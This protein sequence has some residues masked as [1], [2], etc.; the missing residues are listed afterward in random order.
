MH[1]VPAYERRVLNTATSSQRLDHTR[2]MWSDPTSRLIRRPTHPTPPASAAAQCLNEHARNSF[3]NLPREIRDRVYHFLLRDAIDVRSSVWTANP[4]S[5]HDGLL[6]VC[7]QLHDET[8]TTIFA[9]R[10]TQHRT[11]RLTTLPATSSTFRNIRS[12][13][14]EVAPGLDMTILEGI[15]QS[16]QE[17]QLSLQELRL[18]FLT[19]NFSLEP[20][21]YITCGKATDDELIAPS[22]RLTLDPAFVLRQLVVLRKLIVLRQ[23]R[24]LIVENADT[25]LVPAMMCKDKPHLTGLAVV[26]SPQALLH[27][28]GAL[29]LSP[30]QLRGLMV[31]PAPFSDLKVLELSA[32]AVIPAM[33]LLGGAIR[34]L[35]H[36]SWRVPNSDFQDRKSTKFQP[37]VTFYKQTGHM[38]RSLA[39]WNQRLKVLRLCIDLPSGSDYSL[40]RGIAVGDVEGDFRAYLCQLTGLKH[41]E[42]HHSCGRGFFRDELISRLPNGLARLYISESMISIDELITQVQHRFFSYA[43]HYRPQF[44]VGLTAASSRRARSGN[45]AKVPACEYPQDDDRIDTIYI[46]LDESHGMYDQN[47][48]TTTTT[49]VC[50]R[51][52]SRKEDFLESTLVDLYRGENLIGESKTQHFRDN[53]PL[54]TGHLGFITYEY[55]CSEYESEEERFQDPCYE[56]RR[57]SLLK[58]NGRLLDREHNM[59]LVHAQERETFGIEP[60]WLKPAIGDPSESDTY[61]A[62]YSIHVGIY[63]SHLRSDKEERKA[64]E[65]MSELAA[66]FQNNTA[67]KEQHWYFG[68]ESAAQ[69]VFRGEP[70][71]HIANIKHKST[72]ADVEAPLTGRC[73]WAAPEYDVPAIGTWAEPVMPHGWR[74][75]LQTAN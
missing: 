50:P 35:E 38:I 13:S 26:S 34:S 52:L 49:C 51:L 45:V 20:T 42:I 4:T 65:A 19:D 75:K 73:K 43:Y 24:T 6:F 64:Q 7:R 16:L 30:G 17:L 66:C 59:H 46:G 61:S 21:E 70:C 11:D 39:T 63:D 67:L 58:L 14:I 22:R 5:V 40:L 55:A 54:M 53:I 44:A 1:I 27:N 23:L 8:S 29:K 71:A 68:K 10:V 72:V 56:S 15:A 62:H 47:A 25:P 2:K 60:Q 36:L 12:I 41:L 3:L 74:E 69:A 48:A 28:Y 32:N 9:G 18:T 33:D 31:G 57:I 37:K